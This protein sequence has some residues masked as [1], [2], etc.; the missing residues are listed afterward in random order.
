MRFSGMVLFVLFAVLGWAGAAQATVQI[1]IDLSTQRMNVQSSKGS[2]SWPVSTARSGYSTPRGSFAP[3]GMQRMHYSR[4]YHM[5][6]MPH[7]IFFHGGYA[8]HGTYATKALGRP[9]SHGCVRLAPGNAAALYKMVQEE[10]GS[11]S[12]SG[13]PP[14]STRHAARGGHRRHLASAHGRRDAKPL[15]YAPH[16]H[17]RPIGSVRSWQAAPVTSLF[18]F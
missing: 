4:K 13:A 5:S 15:A 12:I 7:S 17:Y 18:D 10:G 8:I 2:F 14:H 6:P 1:H 3:T 11:I 9:A 16:R